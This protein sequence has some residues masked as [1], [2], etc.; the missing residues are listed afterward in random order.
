MT[1]RTQWL[2][3]SLGSLAL[4]ISW[5]ITFENVASAEGFSSKPDRSLL[6]NVSLGA[7]FDL[8][9]DGRS[10]PNIVDDRPEAYSLGA[11]AIGV[12]VGYRFNEIVGLEAGWHE[13]QHRAHREWGG[14]ARYSLGHVAFRLA[15]PLETRQTP[16]LKIGPVVGRFAYGSASLGGYEDN[17]TLT[18]GGIISAVLE[19]ELVLGI[20]ATLTASY[21]P[22]ARFG[23]GG[24]LYLEEFSYESGESTILGSKDFTDDRMVHV[25]WLTAGIQFEWTFR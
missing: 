23:M 10:P 20:V 15:W 16:V 25:I 13:T 12:S 17:D 6:V 24:E 14:T 21:L 4:A 18:A 1:I 3:T 11:F 2:K 19:H 5:V 8:D 22:L 7:G 9:K